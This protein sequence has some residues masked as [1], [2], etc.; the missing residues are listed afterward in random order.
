ME[1]SSNELEQI[2]RSVLENLQDGGKVNLSN[3]APSVQKGDRGVFE[4]V[5][6]AIDASYIA[7]KDWYMNY[8]IEDRERIIAAVRKVAIA[9]AEDFAKRVHEETGMGR[10]EDK[11]IKHVE[12]AKGTPGT[13]C[14]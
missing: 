7:Q 9:N 10:Y 3:N 5:E 8:R 1:I 11:I 12:V 14:L 2:I 4:R 13:E 6:D